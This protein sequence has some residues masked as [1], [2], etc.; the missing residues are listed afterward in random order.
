MDQRDDYQEAKRTHERL[1]EE[2]GKGNIRL[3]SKD[4]V[5]Q[6]RSKQFTG[7]DEGSERVDPKTTLHHQ[8]LHPQVGKQLHGGTLHHGISDF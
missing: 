5:R 1:D 6:L 8:V 2:Q 3:H 7:T 4:Q